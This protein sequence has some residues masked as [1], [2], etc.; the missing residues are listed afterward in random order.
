M[1]LY[2]SNSRNHLPILLKITRK[3]FK[4][5]YKYEVIKTESIFYVLCVSFFSIKNEKSIIKAQQKWKYFG[6]RS[7]FI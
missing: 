7:T 2:R 5:L 6:N 1:F 3:L 4:L